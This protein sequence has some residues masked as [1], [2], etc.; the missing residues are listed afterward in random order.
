MTTDRPGQEERYGQA[1]G[2]KHLKVE[3]DRRCDVDMLVCAGWVQ[4]TLATEL[5][6]LR[7]EFDAARGDLQQA[8]HNAASVWKVAHKLQSEG[9]KI[10]PPGPAHDAIREQ[11]L[12]AAT[13]AVQMLKDAERQALTARAL[14][15]VQLKSLHAT[16]NKLGAYSI[17]LATKLRFMK[18][19]LD[20]LTLAGRALDFWL[21]P[22]CPSCDGRGFHGGV[23]TPIELCPDCH[24]SAKR[25]VNFGGTDADQVFGKRLLAEMDRKADMVMGQ[26]KRFLYSREQERTREVASAELTKRLQGLRSTQAQED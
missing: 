4:E 14:I 8:N 1:I 24:G 20:V 6:R 15:L 9:R 21:D 23:G 22:A 11:R 25:V 19:D 26:W 13:A 2:S 3:V 7:Q 10:T 12:K 18:P 17:A 5:L 16:K